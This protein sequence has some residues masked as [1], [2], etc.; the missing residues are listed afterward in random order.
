MTQRILSALHTHARFF[1]FRLLAA[2]P[3]AV[4][5]CDLDELPSHKCNS[6]AR[7]YPSALESLPAGASPA[8]PSSLPPFGPTTRLDRLRGRGL[9][10]HRQLRHRA[11]R[12]RRGRLGGVARRSRSILLHLPLLANLRAAWQPLGPTRRPRPNYRRHHHTT[13]WGRLRRLF[14]RRQQQHEHEHQQRRKC[15]RGRD[16][17]RRLQQGQLRRCASRPSPPAQAHAGVGRE[18]QRQSIRSIHLA[19]LD[20]WSLP[21]QQ[22]LAPVVLCRAPR[23]RLA[24][25]AATRHPLLGRLH[26]ALVLAHRRLAHR[27]GTLGRRR[28]GA[29]RITAVEAPW[30]QWY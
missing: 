25:P 16:R 24:P 4:D 19:A 17:R 6:D 2:T 3:E 1:V 8:V 5:L 21:R 20:A 23:R 7:T 28:Q 12:Q 14:R 15:R 11:R 30:W 22:P 27:R 9:G 13:G 29:R 18:R 10:A 26:R